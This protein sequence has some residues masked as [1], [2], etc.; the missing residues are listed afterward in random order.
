M[1][2]RLLDLDANQSGAVTVIAA[3]AM[4]VLIG[5]AALAV[6]IG[7][8]KVAKSELQKAADAG[9]LAGAI[10]LGQGSPCPNWSNNVEG[11]ARDTAQ[12]NRVDGSLVAS[13]QVQ[14][15]YWDLSWT[16]PPADQ[17]PL[18]P[19]GLVPGSNDVPAVWVKI[20]KADGQ[21]GGPLTLLFAPILGINS[22][23][24]SAQAVATMCIGVPSIP[25]GSGFPLATPIHFVCEHWQLG[26][27][28]RIG[29]NYHYPDGGQWTSFESEDNSAQTMKNLVRDGNPTEI[30]CRVGNT[31]GDNIYIQPGTETTG[32]SNADCKKGDIVMLPIVADN[33]EP[34]TWTEVLAFVPFYITDA[35]GGDDKYIEGYFVKDY[36]VPGTAGS[37]GAQFYGAKASNRARLVN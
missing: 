9:A 11:T 36:T 27:T 4:V 7:R 31:P 26:D 30:K 19:V 10:A 17:D 13:V 15:G 5:S 6:D 25:S 35:Q 1:K 16:K 23:S 34:K 33:V 20:S 29:S 12:E 32:Y 2:K 14:T 21:N 3:L 8:I 24:L 28:F 18:K 22:A 37:S